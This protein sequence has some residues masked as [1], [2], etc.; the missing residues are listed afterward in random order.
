MM[1]GAG[2]ARPIPDPQIGGHG[3]VVDLDAGTWNATFLD[4]YRPFVVEF[5]ASWSVPAMQSDAWGTATHS[6]IVTTL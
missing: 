1:W 6:H 2:L 5:F 4:D 3:D